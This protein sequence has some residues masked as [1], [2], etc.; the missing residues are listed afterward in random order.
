MIPC[1]YRRTA[2]SVLHRGR[3]EDCR[4]ILWVRLADSERRHST[5]LDLGISTAQVRRIINELQEA[6]P[7][8][9]LESDVFP[10]GVWLI[11]SSHPRVKAG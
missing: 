9:M 3:K 10:L 1:L 8:L 11:Q 5:S 2:Y 4:V 7:R 6:H